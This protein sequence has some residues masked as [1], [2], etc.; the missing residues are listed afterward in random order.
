MQ[1]IINYPKDKET[2]ENQVAH[3][4]AILMKKYID[5][6]NIENKYKIIIKKKLKEELSKT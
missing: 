2:L 5:D 1:L 6:L 3:I 4:K